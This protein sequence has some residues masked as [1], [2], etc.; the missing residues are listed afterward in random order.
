MSLLLHVTYFVY[1]SCM[2]YPYCESNK[3]TFA[4]TDPGF[5]TGTGFLESCINCYIIDT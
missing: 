1:P 5:R 3:E 4:R 2:H